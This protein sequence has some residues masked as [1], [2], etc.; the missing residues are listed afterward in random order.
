M[1][2]VT[3]YRESVPHLY[4]GFE[5]IDNDEDDVENEEHEFLAPR[6]LLRVG[7]WIVREFDDDRYH[8]EHDDDVHEDIEGS[9][10]AHVIA[11]QHEAV[12]G[13]RY[14]RRRDAIRLPRSQLR[15][16]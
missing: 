14:P 9:V 6:F 4:D 7:I 16:L 8:V 12:P 3:S 15:F 10:H 2:N 1:P 13:R 5:Y 11:E